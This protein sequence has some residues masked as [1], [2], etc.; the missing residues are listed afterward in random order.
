MS[1][2]NLGRADYYQDGD[3]NAACGLCGRKRKASEMKIIP[4]GVPGAGLRMCPEHNYE[5][6]PQDFVRGIPDRLT[7]PWTQ[8][9]VDTFLEPT[10]FIEDDGDSTVATSADYDTLVNIYSSV[11]VGTLTITG[12]GTVIVNN[13]GIV[14]ALVNPSATLELH[15]YGVWP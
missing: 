13:Y 7:P 8:P 11:T 14:Q 12:S 1:T 4:P 9:S 3:W 6:N 5:R 2:Y 15:N 10:Y